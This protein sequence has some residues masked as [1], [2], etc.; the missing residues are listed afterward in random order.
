MN[1]HIINFDGTKIGYIELKK[2]YI[3]SM[4]NYITFGND[5]QLLDY[6]TNYYNTDNTTDILKPEESNQYNIISDYGIIIA[7]IYINPDYDT[8]ELSSEIK[9]I[10][11]DKQ[12][13]T[14]ING[15]DNAV[16]KLVKHA[17]N[18]YSEHAREFYRDGGR[19]IKKRTRRHKKK[20]GKKTRRKRTRAN[21]SKH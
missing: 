16:L 17:R 12:K 2:D 7:N 10:N 1:K 3:H 4:H 9:L 15:K 13:T 21:R 5:L 20:R 11:E 19:R 8:H 6:N 18:F 14:T